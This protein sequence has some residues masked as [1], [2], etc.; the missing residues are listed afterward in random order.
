VA[1]ADHAAGPALRSE[2]ETVADPRP[3]PESVRMI[4]PR[5]TNAAI[6]AQASFVAA[7]RPARSQQG[8]D[9]SLDDRIVG[10]GRRPGQ[11]CLGDADHASRREIACLEPRKQLLGVA[12]SVRPDHRVDK[13]NPD[14]SRAD[15]ISG[16]EVAT[17]WMSRIAMNMPR[18]IAPPAGKRNRDHLRDEVGGLDPTHP[19][20]R[21]NRASWDPARFAPSLAPKSTGASRLLPY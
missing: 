21:R 16:S 3:V 7:T 20:R 14:I 2:A 5:S 11:G 6:I 19:L 12:R 13:R 18:H 17:T 9:E 10:R 15:R 8:L 1:A 4:G